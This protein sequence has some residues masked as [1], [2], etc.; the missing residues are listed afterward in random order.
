ML[1]NII[2][3]VGLI[4]ITY[5]AGDAAAQGVTHATTGMVMFV[6]GLML[7]MALD[8]IVTRW[9]PRRAA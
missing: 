1:A 9:M 4:L 8:Q 2:R 3:V 6:L 5:V 7:I